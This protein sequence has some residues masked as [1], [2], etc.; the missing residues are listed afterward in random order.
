MPS[1]PS[2]I[3]RPGASPFGSTSDAPACEIR[4]LRRLAPTPSSNA[5]AGT[6]S[7]SCSARR[8]VTAPWNVMSKF[9][10]A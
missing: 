9:S 7:D 6:L 8:A 10:G 3:A 4:A 5:T 2:A 1:P